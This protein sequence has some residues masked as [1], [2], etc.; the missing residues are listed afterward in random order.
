[1]LITSNLCLPTARTIL[2]REAELGGSDDGWALAV[3][4][5][6]VDNPR[7]RNQVEA[8]AHKAGIA[9]PI[10]G[11][12]DCDRKRRSSPYEKAVKRARLCA[13]PVGQPGWTQGFRF[14]AW[15]RPDA[16]LAFLRN[17]CRYIQ[18]DPAQAAKRDAYLSEH[19]PG[20]ADAAADAMASDAALPRQ[21]PLERIQDL[22][23]RFF[24]RLQVAELAANRA[25]T[26]LRGWREAMVREVAPLLAAVSPI[27]VDP[28]LNERM[29]APPTDAQQ[30]LAREMFWNV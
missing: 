26:Q 4:P 16:E 23:R 3:V 7:F 22:F 12:A 9:W 1:M 14:E 2:Q 21:H 24:D 30:K 17:C 27:T 18:Y 28:Y 10:R 8:M 13:L 25:S 29:L 15:L 6:L 19:F 5:T 11:N 20:S